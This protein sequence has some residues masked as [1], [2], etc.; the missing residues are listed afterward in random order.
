MLATF[1]FKCVWSIHCMSMESTE[2]FV[3]VRLI[4]VLKLHHRYL[5]NIS[6]Y[7]SSQKILL[8]N[9]SA[10]GRHKQGRQADKAGGPGVPILTANVFVVTTIRTSHYRKTDG[11]HH[12]SVYL[13][14]CLWLAL[15]QPQSDLEKL[16]TN[17][18]ESDDTLR[19]IKIGLII[20]LSHALICHRS[21][22][23][24]LGITT[25]QL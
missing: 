12:W 9:L 10:S 23:N 8:Q 7:I 20:P 21:T 17:P 16:E 2:T 11:M 19:H 18:W 1:Y 25:E 24:Q 13:M 14:I 5:W 4:N 3:V 15:T 6:I 22:E